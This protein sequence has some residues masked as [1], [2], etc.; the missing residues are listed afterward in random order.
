MARDQLLS[1][2]TKMLYSFNLTVN[3]ESWRY[4]LITGTGEPA[5]KT[6]VGAYAAVSELKSETGIPKEKQ[7]L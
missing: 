3:L 2:I 6:C 7:S 1:G 5:G 4:S